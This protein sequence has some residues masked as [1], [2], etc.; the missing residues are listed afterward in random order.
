MSITPKPSP[1]SSSPGANA[2]ALEEAAVTRPSDNAMPA[3]VTANPVAISVFCAYFL[4]SRAAAS[5][6]TRMP[7]VAAVKMTPVLIAL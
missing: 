2:Q 1:I 6:E 3:A 4:A 7:S 5:E